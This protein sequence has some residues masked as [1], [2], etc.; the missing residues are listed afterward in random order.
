V[1]IFHL[2][3]DESKY[4]FCHLQ[5]FYF[6]TFALNAKQLTLVSTQTLVSKYLQLNLEMEFVYFHHFV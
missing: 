2:D 6:S 3:I 4:L 1:K 5:I